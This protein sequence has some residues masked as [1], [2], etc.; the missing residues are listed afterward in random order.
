[1]SNRIVSKFKQNSRGFLKDYRWFIVVFTFSLLCDAASTIVFMLREGP[2]IEM[3]PVIRYVSEMLGPIL[4]PLLSAAFKIAAGT[5]VAIYCRRFAA[6]IFITV[7]IISFWAAWYNIW[8][9]K[10]Y[11]PNIMVWFPL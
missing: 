9:Y 11:T 4:G 8:G 10:I 6:H 7:S 1:L 3:H 2:N 5:A